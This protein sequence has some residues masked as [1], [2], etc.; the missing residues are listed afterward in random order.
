MN[1]QTLLSHVA[2]RAS[3]TA[4][5]VLCTVVLLGLVAATA[6]AQ[7]RGPQ[8]FHVP[9]GFSVGA[10]S[11]PAGTYTIKP[12]SQG[13]LAIVSAKGS[14]SA[15]VLARLEQCTQTGSH[16][17]L[18]FNRYGDFHYLS[19]VRPAGEASLLVLPRSRQ[20]IELAKAWEQQHETVVASISTRP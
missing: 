11:F 8:R 18:V 4:T 16:G 15:L 20:E 7:M 6:P 5:S 13:V 10:K 2:R 19:E 3:R 17:A 9:F 1:T 12:M 14:R